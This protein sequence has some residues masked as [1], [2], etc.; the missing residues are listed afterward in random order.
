LGVFAGCVSLAAI[1]ARRDEPDSMSARAWLS[2]WIT[3]V[4]CSVCFSASSALAR[5]SFACS[6]C[7]SKK[8]LR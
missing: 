7:C 2:S 8:S 5:L 3:P 6:S 4:L 1:C